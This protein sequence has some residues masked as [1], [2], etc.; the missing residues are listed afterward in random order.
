MAKRPTV[1]IILPVLNE[2]K[3]II[4]TLKH[5]ESL[6][7]DETI[8]VDGGSDD[9]TFEHIRTNQPS[10][11]LFSFA[12][13]N[14]A[15]QMNLGAT[16]SQSDVLLFAHA[17]MR[18]PPDALTRIQDVIS[19]GYDG[20]GFYKTYEPSSPLLEAYSSFL[21]GVYL[22]CLRSMVGTNGI[23]VKRDLFDGLDGYSDMGFMED[24]DFSTRLRRKGR[25]A[26]IHKAI[27]VSSR[28]YM[29]LGVGKQII[30]NAELMLRYKLLRQDP[31]KLKA[32]YMS[33]R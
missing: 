25:V 28:R 26:V 2:T 20:G 17:D 5:L 14:R 30:K 24:V 32:L 31:E 16:K 4:Q 8:V 13:R 9:G 29:E 3:I 21:N 15:A 27:K 10:I 11:K 18:F 22:T 33:N 23:Y 19:K 6:S 1:A 7:P 12:K